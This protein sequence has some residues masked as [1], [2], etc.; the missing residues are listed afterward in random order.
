MIEINQ[1][2]GLILSGG[3]DHFLFIRKLYDMELLI[4][5]KFKKKYIITMAKISPM[6]LLYVI[7]F[8]KFKK[9]SVIFGYTLNGILFAKSRYAY[10]DTLDFTKTGNIVTW[11]NKKK[12]QVLLSNDLQE[13][14]YN[15]NDK[16]EKK[17]I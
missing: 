8:H 3:D 6:N 11:T 17:K 4:P 13:K 5:I 2:L 12:I 7:C 15:K 16:I 14:S 10:Y 1:R 9:K